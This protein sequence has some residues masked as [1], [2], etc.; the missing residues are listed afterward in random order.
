MFRAEPDPWQ[1]EALQA[2]DR[3]EH[4][5]A[6]SGHGVGK[7]TL[8]AWGVIQTVACF[9]YCKV[10]CTAPTQHQLRDLLW[11]EI[12]YWINRSPLKHLLTWTATT[13]SPKGKEESWFAVARSSSKAENMAG[14]HAP[15]LRFF[16]DETS[17]VLDFIMQ[18]VDGALS[19]EGAQIV[20]AS[21]PTQI[22]GYFYDAFHKNRSQFYT[23]TISSE[24]SPRVSKDYPSM[25]ASKWGKDSDIYRV[26]VQGEFPQ[27][28]AKGFISL[29]TV[30]AAV[31]RWPDY[32]D[33]GVV[34]IGLDVARYGDDETVFAVRHGNKVVSIESHRGWATT[35]TTGRALQLIREH[36]ATAIKIDDASMGGGVTDQ[37]RENQ[38]VGCT[39][40]V[41]AINFGGAG[42][43]H[44]DNYSAVMWADVRD[45]LQVGDIALPDDEDLIA[46]LTTRR[47]TI[48]SKGRIA[49]ERKED[50]K[51]RG[52]PSPDRADAV[53]LAFAG[54]N[55]L[56]M[57]IVHLSDINTETSES[58]DVWAD[59][60][61]EDL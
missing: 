35:Q 48:T 60:G 31:T 16:I 23:M 17:G 43:K 13:L 32:A 59:E 34:E 49:L 41:I 51:R 61:W 33:D 55:A 9:P 21:N 57:G 52:L 8:M 15:K 1:L 20:M 24:D 44:Y 28:E 37:L 30:E 29:S 50:M 36:K 39:Y 25:M 5:A 26:R 47:Y 3:G 45:L 11:A 22:S 7:T 27:A 42:D 53:V 40:K 56:P 58:A 46:Q 54:A 14:F 10:P 2:M 6:K 12:A 18:V 38:E 4:I 19:T